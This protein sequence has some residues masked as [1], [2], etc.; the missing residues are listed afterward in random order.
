MEFF[1]PRKRFAPHRIRLPLLS[2]AGAVRAKISNARRRIRSGA[3]GLPN[4]ITPDLLNAAAG[5][6]GARATIR[7]HNNSRYNGLSYF[8]SGGLVYNEITKRW[9]VLTHAES[10][11]KH[12]VVAAANFVDK[13]KVFTSTFTCSGVSRQQAV[14]GIEGSHTKPTTHLRK[15]DRPI[16]GGR[17]QQGSY[18]VP[19]FQ[20]HI[21]RCS[22]PPA[23]YLVYRRCDH[24]R[25]MHAHGSPRDYNASTIN[26]NM[27]RGELD[28]IVMNRTR[29]AGSRSDG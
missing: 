12:S 4:R 24:A 9:R 13:I 2:D 7:L 8:V 19:T 16:S 15:R 6:S 3:F 29:A 10:P 14:L 20:Q 5:T 22:K 21:G 26:V 1:Q 11:E 17:R 18:A 25:A 23:T 28:H 27:P